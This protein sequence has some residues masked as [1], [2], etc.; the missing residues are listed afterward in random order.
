MAG[1]EPSTTAADVASTAMVPA[2]RDTARPASS[3][4]Y[5]SSLSLS[6]SVCVCVSFSTNMQ[7]T[8][9][10][11]QPL[12]VTPSSVGNGTGD[13]TA[14]QNAYF[15]Q[16]NSLGYYNNA[17]H[18]QYGNQFAAAGFNPG[19]NQQQMLQQMMLQQQQLFAMQQMQNQQVSGGWFKGWMVGVG[20]AL[21]IN[22]LPFPTYKLYQCNAMLRYA[23]Q[24]AYCCVGS[25]LEASP[26][27]RPRTSTSAQWE[28]NSSST[29]ASSSS[30]SSSSSSR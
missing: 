7:H 19:F 17:A 10:N 4:R 25:S 15:A 24:T 14:E 2:R 5:V 30:S 22:N 18:S 9:R 23:M 16:L 6:L 13:A 21:T 26:R 29:P 1:V 3:S 27:R 20:E 12:G 28:L 11:T 8:T